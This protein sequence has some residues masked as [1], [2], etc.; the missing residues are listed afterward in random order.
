MK[1][2]V[3]EICDVVF[4]AKKA[5][6]LGKYS[7]SK[8]QPVLYIDSAKASTIEGTASTVY[9]QGG[10]GNSRLIAWEG[11]KSLTFTVE[12]ALLSERGL[13]ILSGAGLWQDGKNGSKSKTTALL[14]RTYSDTFTSNLDLSKYIKEVEPTSIGL[15]VN[16][17]FNYDPQTQTMTLKNEESKTLPEPLFQ[18]DP[19]A[20]RYPSYDYYIYYVPTDS[21]ETGIVIDPQGTGSGLIYPKKVSFIENG[22]LD[23]IEASYIS[24][25]TVH[26]IQVDKNIEEAPFGTFYSPALKGN[27]FQMDRISCISLDSNYSFGKEL[28]N[29]VDIYNEPGDFPEENW[30]VIEFN[31][32]NLLQFYVDYN[33]PWTK[34][35][36][37]VLLDYYRTDLDI[38]AE[39]EIDAKNFADYYYVEATTN[40]R[41][42]AD[43]Q[44]MQAMITF[45]NVKVQSNFTFNM[46]AS[47]DPS[48]FSFV[49]DAMPGYTENNKS[50]KVLCE[51]LIVDDTYLSGASKTELNDSVITNDYSAAKLLKAGDDLSNGAVL[52]L[53]PVGLIKDRNY[54]VD[55]NISS[56][57]LDPDKTMEGDGHIGLSAS[58]GYL[59]INNTPTRIAL[60]YDD[61]NNTMIIPKLSNKELIQGPDESIHYYLGE[62]VQITSIEIQNTNWY[63]PNMPSQQERESYSIKIKN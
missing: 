1:F 5:G 10:K 14:H 63:D 40:F 7:Y 35:S 3:R 58:G 30:F 60:K 4:K 42:Q 44:D 6:A 55:I 47:G 54:D 25:F 36:L 29:L 11:E 43:G 19:E 61:N 22:K 13:A 27:Y 31:I 26:I 37:N 24:S 46:A 8:G 12:D 15:V 32:K 17:F 56:C 57:Y 39:F 45:P 33:I 16:N 9:A 50:K 52:Y 59:Y 51:M 2:G 28:S 62:S 38:F 49:M 18:Y 34:K 48:T 21:T 53:A 20:D 41:R 23:Q